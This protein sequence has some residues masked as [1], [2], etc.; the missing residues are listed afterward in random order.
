M[1]EFS[2]SVEPT[3]NQILVMSHNLKEKFNQTVSVEVE[4]WY[5]RNEA[6]PT[7]FFRIYIGKEESREGEEIRY[8]YHN[9]LKTWAKCQEIYLRLMSG[10]EKV[11][12]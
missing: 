9:N 3:I 6:K 2:V 7:I 10:E 4:V 12:E 8:L 11:N 1:K 5:F